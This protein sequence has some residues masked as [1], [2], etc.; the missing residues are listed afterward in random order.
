MRGVIAL[1]TIMRWPCGGSA[2]LCERWGGGADLRQSGVRCLGSMASI[3][4]PQPFDRLSEAECK[5]GAAA[6]VRPIP[7]SR[8]PE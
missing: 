1:A 7:R 5:V 8:P 3:L 6:P 4:L 2:C